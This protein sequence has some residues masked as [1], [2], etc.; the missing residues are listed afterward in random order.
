MIESPRRD[1][2]A[3]IDRVAAR[4]VE[5]RGNEELLP[6]TIAQLPARQTTPWFLAMRVQLAAA[7]VVMLVAFLV[8][9]SS[10]EVP[11]LEAPHVAAI[12]GAESPI[13]GPR[14]PIPDPGSPIPDPRSLIPAP[15]SAVPDPRSDHERGLAPVAAIDA[16]ELSGIAPPAMELDAAAA[17]EPLVLP[18]LALDNKGDS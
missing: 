5:V 1:L 6:R 9:R 8:A 15:R 11:R 2:D 18:E 3:A 13:P 12:A 10:R 17:L 14:S 7:A 16:I 4:L